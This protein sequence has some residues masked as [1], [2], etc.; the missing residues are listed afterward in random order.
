MN[1]KGKKVSIIGV[2]N[3]GAT[4]AYT[5]TIDGM[6][7]EIVLIDVNKEKAKGEAMDI[8][9]GTPFSHHVNIYAGDYSAAADSDI[10]VLTAG[11][12]RKPGQTRIDLAQTNIDIIKNVMPNLLKYA[13]NAIYIVVSN[14]V[15]ILT[16]AVTKTFGLPATQVIGSGTM[17][18]TARLRTLI[19]EHVS[20]PSQNVHA[21]VLGEHGDTS[22]IPWSLTSIA[23]MPM[24]SYC[25]TIC[26]RHNHCGKKELDYIVD[27]MRT[28]GAKVIASKGATFY[29]VA[30]STRKLCDS[31]L[32]DTNAIHTV[33]S[34]LNGQFGIE[35]VCV[36]IPYVIGSNGIVRSLE[37]PLTENEHEQLVHSADSLK[38]VIKSLNI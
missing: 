29:A 36:S 38:E 1:K 31:I 15:D 25:E 37:V 12:G 33:S 23:G 35:D 16:Y 27:D 28:A 3:V 19:A 5:L 8:I 22:M 10:V 24:E 6:A 20:I 2:G 26:P 18:D 17:L 9:Q 21:Y 7:N 30:L 34:L 13:P 32:R 4:I 11:I 14:P